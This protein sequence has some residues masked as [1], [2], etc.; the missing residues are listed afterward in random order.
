MLNIF[1]KYFAISI[2]L[3]ILSLYSHAGRPMVVDDAAL[4]PPKSCQIEMWAQDNIEN[5]EYWVV[6][7]CN[8]GRNLELAIGTGKITDHKDR[9]HFINIQAKTL[10]KPLTTNGWGVGFSVA[11]QV[12]TNNSKNDWQFNIPV[13][14]SMLN[15]H[16]LIHL[17]AGVSR[18]HLTHRNLTTWGIG[19]ETQIA[20]PIF[21]T[22]EV[23]GNDRHES[24]YQTGF[25]HMLYKDF[26]QLDASYGNSF[27][28]SDQQFFSLGLVFQ[29]NKILP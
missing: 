2:F 4:V 7:A 5:N 3:S 24:F 14:F 10:L 9:N 16:F 26:V 25:K 28:T 18:E 11:S 17:N 1:K 13:S 21:L 8:S 23:Y 19:T 20:S 22:A 29:S 6:P 27:S 12:D 15:D